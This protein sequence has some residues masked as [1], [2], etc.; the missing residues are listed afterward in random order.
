M[1]YRE[2]WKDYKRRFRITAVA[3]LVPP[4]AIYLTQVAGALQVWLIMAWLT[5][6]AVAMT[7][8]FSFRCPRCGQWFFIK[9][10][11]NSPLAGAC[12]NCGLSKWAL[13]DPAAPAPT[14][15]GGA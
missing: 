13:E 6:F 9:G 12:V 8:L 7:W 1:S 10:V 14:G 3:W 15:G 4:A 2:S 11:T 5:A